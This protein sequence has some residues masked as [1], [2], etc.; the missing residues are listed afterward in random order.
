MER[1]RRGK[2]KRLFSFLIMTVLMFIVI[3]GFNAE[4][5][6]MTSQDLTYNFTTDALAS[7]NQGNEVQSKPTSSKMDPT[8]LLLLGSGLIGLAGFGRKNM[9]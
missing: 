7:L 6:S 5:L 2:V 8:T 4:D 9:K 1:R 3:E